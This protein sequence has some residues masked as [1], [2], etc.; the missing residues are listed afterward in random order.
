MPKPNRDLRPPPDLQ[1]VE[2]VT[3]ST[4]AQV[5]LDIGAMLEFKGENRFK[6]Q[7]Y[8]RAA[9]TLLNLPEDIRVP[10]REGRLESLPN[11]GEAISTKI[12]ELLRTG[13]LG[14]HERLKA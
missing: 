14:L 13:K 12:D 2:G 7:S 5:M 10:W 8:R 11:V 4:I 1:P 3:N 6:V 9:D